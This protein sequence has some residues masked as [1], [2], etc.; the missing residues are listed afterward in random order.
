MDLPPPL[1]RPSLP[2]RN[3][4]KVARQATSEV[5]FEFAPAVIAE[6]DPL[7][8]FTPYRH[9]APRRNSI[10]PDLQ[11]AFIARLAETGIV[12]SA[13]AHIG[14]SLEALYKLRRQPG[15]PALWGDVFDLARLLC[16]RGAERAWLT[17][18]KRRESA[19]GPNGSDSPETNRMRNRA[20]NR[21]ACAAACALSPRRP[22]DPQP[23]GAKA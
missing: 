11:R 10:T 12:K 5:A 21:A 4:R 13:A 17:S 1:E 23:R 16:H 15:A 2:K 19:L 7:L 6:D 20:A 18:G 3:K 22:P 8:D 14:R 9:K